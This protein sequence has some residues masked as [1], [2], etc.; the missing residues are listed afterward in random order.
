MNLCCRPHGHVIR[1]FTPNAVER[2][3][4]QG[5]HETAWCNGPVS[6]IRLGMPKWGRRAMLMGIRS[7]SADV[8]NERGADAM[9]MWLNELA[10]WSRGEQQPLQE[11]GRGS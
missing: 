7:V 11:N 9:Q 6:E 8:T 1:R 3:R 10:R 2:H 5:S 4:A